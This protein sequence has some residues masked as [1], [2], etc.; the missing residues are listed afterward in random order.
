MMN[1]SGKNDWMQANADIFWGDIARRDHVV[2]LYQNDEILLDTLTGFVQNAIDSNENAMVIATDSHL[3]ALE[4]RIERYGF[5]IDKLI[6]DGQFIPLDVEEVIAEFMIDGKAEESHI[7]ET[8][9]GLFTKGVNN[10]RG[11]RLCG[12]IAHTL[13]AQGHREIA[14][15]V[16]RIADSLN[17]VN[18]T[19]VFCIYSKN[20]VGDDPITYDKVICA[21]HSKM[22]S[23]SE[24][25]LTQ[26]FYRNM[27]GIHSYL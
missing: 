15:E 24:K 25:Q 3:N 1:T 7:A 19:C 4:S 17:H 5:H 21:Q 20:L 27:T 10:N 23:G 14:T 16:E 8:M 26:V 11:F 9:S 6:F 12:E 22:I 13:L 18:P 2:Q